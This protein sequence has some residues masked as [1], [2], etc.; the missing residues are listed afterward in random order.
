M[1]RGCSKDP[2][3]TSEVAVE[4]YE[5][6]MA[7]TTICSTSSCNKVAGATDNLV[8]AVAGSAP[9][10]GATADGENDAAAD[11]EEPAPDSSALSAV[12][13]ALALVF[14]LAL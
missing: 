4:G 12:V 7:K 14:A 8:T 3:G 2:S 11:S 6:V 9:A 5:N 10:G 1:V 13:A